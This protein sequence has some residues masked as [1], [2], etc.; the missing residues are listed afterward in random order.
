[1]ALCL[2]RGS[3]IFETQTEVDG[4]IR[5]KLPIILREQTV[6]R[7]TK[8][9]ASRG[10]RSTGKRV[11]FNLFEN[12][13]SVREVPHTIKDQVRASAP[14]EGVIILLMGVLKSELPCFVADHFIEDVPKRESI[15]RHY[16]WRRVSLWG[17]IHNA[18]ALRRDRVLNLD[19][20][21]SEVDLRVGTD[22]VVAVTREVE[23]R[24]VE[25][26]G[27]DGSDPGKKAARTKVL[28]AVIG[29]RPTFRSGIRG[30]GVV[31][32]EESIGRKKILA[33]VI[34]NPNVVLVAFSC[35]GQRYLSKLEIRD[36]IETASRKL[37]WVAGCETWVVDAVNGVGRSDVNTSRNYRAGLSSCNPERT[38]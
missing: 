7:A 1:M 19:A 8:V 18:L 38:S 36:A 20:G 3:E 12:R 29:R 6:G 27:V 23:A 22:S 13:C 34:V 11:N 14:N 21:D 9:L 37:S 26:R 17:S 4:E 25:G 33:S 31:E 32:G 28:S 16:S 5:A 15:L 24:L 10:G 2:G 30:D 35:G